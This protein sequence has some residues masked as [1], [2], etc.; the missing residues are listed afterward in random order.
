MITRHYSVISGPQPSRD[1]DSTKLLTQETL[2][3][4]SDISQHRTLCVSRLLPVTVMETEEKTPGGQVEGAPMI[5]TEEAGE[6]QEMEVQGMVEVKVEPSQVLTVT[7]DPSMVKSEPV[8]PNP[9]SS[10]TVRHAV[11]VDGSKLIIPDVL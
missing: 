7:V 2:L 9:T 5:K 8:E 1:S 6:M 3:F 4:S 11:N 10:A